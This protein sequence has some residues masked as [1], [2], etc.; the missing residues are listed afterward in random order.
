MSN[1]IRNVGESVADAL[2][3]LSV[4]FAKDVNL[5][6]IMT[7]PKNPDCYMVISNENP[8]VLISAVNASRNTARVETG[9]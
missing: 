7:D 2:N 8:D 6:F 9:L 3:Q 5:T 4:L 1:K